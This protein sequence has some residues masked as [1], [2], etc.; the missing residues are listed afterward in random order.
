MNC[1]ELLTKDKG[2]EIAFIVS[3]K[4]E[5]IINDI[6]TI[7]IELTIFSPEILKIQV[8]AFPN[9]VSSFP[10]LKSPISSTPLKVITVFGLSS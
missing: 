10:P 1:W 9:Q 8:K 5:N 3:T 2:I 6:G 7:N 4:R